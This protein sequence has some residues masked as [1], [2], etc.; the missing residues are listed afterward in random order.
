MLKTNIMS[1]K[2]TTEEF[3]EKAKIVH[4]GKY[5]YSMSEYINGREKTIIICPEHGGFLQFPMKHLQGQGCP[6]C[7]KMVNKIK[8]MKSMEYYIPKMKKIHH[9]RYEY[10]QDELYNGYKEKITI[11]CPIHGEFKQTIDDHMQGKGCPKCGHITSKI[12]DIIIA[13]IR[14]HYKGEII[15]NARNIIKD[16]ELDIYLPEL[17]YA[18]EFNGLRWHCELYKE[19]KN[20]HLNKL[21]LCK[22]KG[23]NLIQIFEDEWLEN[24]TLVL[25]KILHIIHC[26]PNVN[27]IMGRKVY[28]EEIDFEIS[29]EFLN[30]FHIQKGCK[31]TVYLGAF[32]DDKLIGVM[33]FLHDNG[34]WELTRFA[35]D[36]NYICQGVGGKLFNYFIKKYNPKEIKSF[37]D[38]RWTTNEN[39]NLYTKL[40]FE[41]KDI[42]S[43]DYRYYCPLIDRTKRIHKFNFRKNRLHKKFNLPLTMTEAQMCEQI[44]AYKIWDCGLIKYVWKQKREVN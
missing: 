29:T 40:G 10:T 22:E 7:A 32:Y 21:N 23:I 8:H 9:E 33:T 24:Q 6:E 35:S 12:E 31:S 27:K 20:Y 44:K 17:N 13:F 41:L 36:F 16:F 28:I 30:R 25:Y 19:D 2:Y 11:T 26:S 18:I 43:P 5:D 15:A 14:E 34:K 42:L 39:N 37:A 3:I 38:R 4:N 1:H